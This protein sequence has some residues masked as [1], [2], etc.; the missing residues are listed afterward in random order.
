MQLGLLCFLQKKKKKKKGWEL[1]GRL[2]CA[3][4]FKAKKSQGCGKKQGCPIGNLNQ[5]ETG[6]LTLQAPYL[7]CFSVVVVTLQSP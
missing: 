1:C 4:C 6:R 3:S 2:L 5:S 7:S